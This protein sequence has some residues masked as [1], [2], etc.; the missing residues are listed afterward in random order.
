MALVQ[1]KSVEEPFDG[2]QQTDKT[3]PNK[4]SLDTILDQL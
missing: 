3:V 1:G 2:D 4:Q